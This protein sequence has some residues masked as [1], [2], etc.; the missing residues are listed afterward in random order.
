MFLIFFLIHGAKEKQKWLD[1]LDARKKV[2]CKFAGFGWGL[3]NKVPPKEVEGAFWMPRGRSTQPNWFFRACILPSTGN[4][5]I[6][7]IL[8]SKKVNDLT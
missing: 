3:I 6:F 7:P 5:D 2:T 8:G 1:S 4:V